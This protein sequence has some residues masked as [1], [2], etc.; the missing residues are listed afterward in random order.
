MRVRA[1]VHERTMVIEATF[2][3]RHVAASTRRE[4]W[5]LVGVVA[6]MPRKT[7]VVA[8]MPRGPAA[9]VWGSWRTCPDTRGSWHTHPR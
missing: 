2:T 7:G 6:H 4:A 1:L 3:M 8:P 5:P 9:A